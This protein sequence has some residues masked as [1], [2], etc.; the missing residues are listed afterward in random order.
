M[1]VLQQRPPRTPGHALRMYGHGSPG[2][3][4][5]SSP[6]R[7][8]PLVPA[9]SRLCWG[10]WGIT[11]GV[12]SRSAEP[13]EG[14]GAAGRAR[15]VPGSWK[16][17]GVLKQKGGRLQPLA[18]LLERIPRD[19]GAARLCSALLCSVC[20]QPAPCLSF[21]IPA[22]LAGSRLAAPW[23]SA[24]LVSPARGRG[25][26]PGH[27]VPE[28]SPPRKAAIGTILSG[29]EQGAGAEN[30]D[31]S[32]ADI[33]LGLLCR[34]S[35]HIAAAGSVG[36]AVPGARSP[37]GRV[38]CPGDWHPHLPRGRPPRPACPG[39]SVAH[40]HAPVTAGWPRGGDGDA[41]HGQARSGGCQH[42][43]CQRGGCQRSRTEDAMPGAQVG[44]LL[45]RSPGGSCES[46]AERGRGLSPP[47]SQARHRAGQRC[48]LCSWPSW[49]KWVSG[50]GA[51]GTPTLSG[52]TPVPA[53]P[54]TSS[55]PRSAAALT[56][57]P[58]GAAGG[59]F[60]GDTCPR[61]AGQPRAAAE[62]QFGVTVLGRGW[63]GC[64]GD[65]RVA[66]DTPSVP[67]FSA[68]HHA[69][70]NGN[71]ELI[72][73]LLEAQ[74][75]VDI[76]DNKGE[77]PAPGCSPLPRAPCWGGTRRA[78]GRSAPQACGPCTT[79]PGRARRSP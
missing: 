12:T 49:G 63:Q 5:S 52:D 58:H 21:P 27:E 55:I 32:Q 11:P 6:G 14:W 61:R 25:A 70:L 77:S 69:A 40:S 9:S 22:V 7:W 4:S 42:G 56:P 16:V 71:T 30:V 33:G 13:A 59:G 41:V 72:S 78:H 67:R 64:G 47:H 18:L 45:A 20:A 57:K 35:A 74:A 75:A 73:L 15:L 10:Q 34:L 2:A 38:P 79:R 54:S 31:I 48:H 65:G 60:H 50:E 29:F 66:P 3:S 51:P 23:V 19:P 26:R 46:R 28:G 17:Q 8:H 44:H 62:V 43:G 39:G 1:G 37:R 24:V 68:L 76:K 53:L 36:T